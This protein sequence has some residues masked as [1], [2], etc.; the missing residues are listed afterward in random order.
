[1]AF[2]A[3]RNNRTDDAIQIAEE[4]IQSESRDYR[5]HLWLGRLLA[6]TGKKPELAEES[7][8][9][10]VELE[11]H[12]AETWVALVRF[13]AGLKDKKKADDARTLLGVI[14]SSVKAE[15]SALA[16]AQCYNALGENDRAR[17]FYE[18]AVKARPTD[19]AI[20]GDF[21][22]FRMQHNELKEAE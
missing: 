14:Q 2:I 18:Q 19:A 1:A 3:L 11:N 20:L 8:R 22:S 16:M 7:L 13:L 9:K 6:A 5:D 12:T 21:A 10:A 15:E 4:A 17:E